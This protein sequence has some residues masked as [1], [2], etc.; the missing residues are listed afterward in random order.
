VEFLFVLLLFA[1]IVLN[2][3]VWW[4]LRHAPVGDTSPPWR[5]RIAHLGLWTN[6]SAYV[7]PWAQI[8][9]TFILLN[10]GRPVPA[11]DL[12]DGRVVVGISVALAALS[13]MFGAASPK[14]V[15]IP[16]LLSAVSVACLWLSIPMG[17]L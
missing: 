2:A 16:L 1:P 10:S 6:S 4:R 7:I 8:L 5:I 3:F 15:R 9:Y 17:V 11:D 13:G 14:H 12:I